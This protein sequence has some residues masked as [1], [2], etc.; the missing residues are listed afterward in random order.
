MDDTFRDLRR[1]IYSTVEE[2]VR[3]RQLIVNVVLA[4][5]IMDK[6][7]KT[8]RNQRWNAA[9]SENASEEEDHTAVN[10]NRKATIVIEVSH[11]I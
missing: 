2:F 7:L 9:F 8:L 10:R 11:E 3:F 5:D 1:T 4:T 6:D